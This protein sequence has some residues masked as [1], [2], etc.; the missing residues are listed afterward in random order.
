MT[1]GDITLFI[2]DD[3]GAVRDADHGLISGSVA[4]EAWTINPSDPLSARGQCHWTDELVR[5]DISLRTEATCM[6]TSSA[7]AFHLNARIEAYENDEMIY[8]RDIEDNI[9]RENL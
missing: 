5:G 9:P 1:T 4:R 6:M 8:A 7:T 2:E 3:F